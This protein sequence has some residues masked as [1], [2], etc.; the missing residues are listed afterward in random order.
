[1]TRH[2]GEWPGWTL[3]HKFSLPHHAQM[4]IHSAPRDHGTGDAFAKILGDQTRADAPPAP[5]ADLP[6]G[7]MASSKPRAAAADDLFPS[8]TPSADG[9]GSSDGPLPSPPEP[10][11]SA[12]P[13]E[14]AGRSRPGAQA[15]PEAVQA[16]STP[17]EP[18]PQS[19]PKLSVIARET[20]FN[21]ESL[22]LRLAAGGLAQSREPA[23]G[24]APSEAPA[25]TRLAEVASSANGPLKLLRIRLETENADPIQATLRL[26]DGALDIHLTASSDGDVAALE[27]GAARLADS[28][29]NSGYELGD[30]V[31]RRTAR[32][33][34]DQG[35]PSDE[36][37]Q[38]D[39]PPARHDPS[40]GAQ[41]EAGRPRRVPPGRSG[42]PGDQDNGDRAPA[43]GHRRGGLYL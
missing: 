23:A 30:I 4:R 13:E 26:R 42:Q 12:E 2:A 31:I 18:A 36:R 35:T 20:H 1:M 32:G 14:S 3:I 27:E 40:G 34:A 17:E 33:E 41:Q 16:A 6:S 43:D 29:E 39:G 15:S 10:E 37:R 22:K 28:L 11:A 8:A 24:P 9:G 5:E 21:P 38:D 7:D 25:A 19:A